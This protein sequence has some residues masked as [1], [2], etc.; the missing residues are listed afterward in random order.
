MDGK[1]SN[2]TGKRDGRDWKEEEEGWREVKGKG[3]KGMER[4]LNGEGTEILMTNGWK[5]YS[6][7]TEK[8]TG[9]CND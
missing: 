9:Y 6:I 7:W 5:D 8:R 4:K 3:S 2:R 1:I